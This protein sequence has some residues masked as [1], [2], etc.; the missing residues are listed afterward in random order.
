MTARRKM[1]TW[2]ALLRGVN[3]GT[4]R[5]VPMAELKAVLDGRGFRNVATLLNSGNAVFKADP[6]LSTDLNLIL[7]AALASRFGFEVPVVVKSLPEL[8]Q[9]IAEN[10]LAA[11]AQ[12]HSR[13]LC[14][15]AQDPQTLAPVLKLAGLTT[16]PERFQLGQHAAFLDC[17]DG[18]RD[19]KAAKALLGKIGQHVTTRNWATVL[20]LHAL[21]ARCAD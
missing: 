5:R 8:E 9:I 18:I 11:G 12:D 14:A 3:V 6:P 16:P 15:L 17:A 10:S 19:S 13:L 20:R 21:A 4:A 2:I 1:Q 7:G